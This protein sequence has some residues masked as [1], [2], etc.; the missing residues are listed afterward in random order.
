MHI[1]RLIGSAKAVARVLGGSYPPHDDKSLNSELWY[2]G[3]EFG[4][5]THP[6]LYVFFMHSDCDGEISPENCERIAN[7]MEP[8]LPKLDAMG[9]GAG[10]I[11]SRGGYGEVCRKFIAGCREAARSNEPLEFY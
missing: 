4:K 5:D 10:H 1:R 9:M 2:W 3:D 6:G 8:L 7:E 11:A